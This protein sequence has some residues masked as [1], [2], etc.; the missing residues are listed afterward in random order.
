MLLSFMAIDITADDGMIACWRRYF[1]IIDTR[2][3]ANIAANE[4]CCILFQDLFLSMMP[5]LLRSYKSPAPAAVNRCCNI[6]THMA[7]IA[8]TLLCAN[9]VFG[10][11][12]ASEA[13]YEREAQQVS[14][15]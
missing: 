13:K 14:W 9:I 6:R 8:E 7:G 11:L 15:R 3:F 2:T 1:I 5:L 10:H 12:C 4:T